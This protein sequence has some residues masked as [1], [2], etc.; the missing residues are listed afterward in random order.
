MQR[1]TLTRDQ[2]FHVT[3]IKLDIMSTPSSPRKV[4][5]EEWG[6]FASKDSNGIHS[7]TLV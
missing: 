2:R 5:D 1:F 4:R 6:F 7:L 3:D